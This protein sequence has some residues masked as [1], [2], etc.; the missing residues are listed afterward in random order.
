[1][2]RKSTQALL[3]TIILLLGTWTFVRFIGKDKPSP[4]AR[5][6]S[7][8]QNENDQMTW[9]EYI[10]TKLQLVSREDYVIL[11]LYVEGHDICEL[12]KSVEVTFRSE[13]IA[14][15]G[16]PSRVKQVTNCQDFGFT[17]AW[18][19]QLMQDQ[20]GIQKLGHFEDE[21]EEWALESFVLMGPHGTLKLSGVEIFRST[22]VI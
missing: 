15:S 20:E 19:R 14:Y 13:G 10:S 16:E 4:F 7:S 18:P 12:W 9:K 5:G 22:G 17:Q 8:L 11:N 1:M 6:P 21:P 2:K 3:F